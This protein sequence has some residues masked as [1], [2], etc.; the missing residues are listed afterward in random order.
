MDAQHLLPRTFFG[1]EIPESRT[2]RTIDPGHEVSHP[3]TATDSRLSS[4]MVAEVVFVLETTAKFGIICGTNCIPRVE[5]TGA[6]GMMSVNNCRA[7]RL[8][9]RSSFGSRRFRPH[10]CTSL[11]LMYVVCSC[12]CLPI[13]YVGEEGNSPT[14]PKSDQDVSTSHERPPS[15]TSF[16]TAACCKQLHQLVKWRCPGKTA[17]TPYDEMPSFGNNVQVD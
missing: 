17:T 11:C 2:H 14:Q 16:H 1:N 12:R 4:S 3:M 6:D 10:P 13:E 9:R 5:L 8:K 7:T 15:S